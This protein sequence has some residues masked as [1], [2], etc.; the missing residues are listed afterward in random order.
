[1][2]NV[3]N[4]ESLDMHHSHT[5]QET[6]FV[7]KVICTYSKQHFGIPFPPVPQRNVDIISKPLHLETF[8]LEFH[9]SFSCF[10]AGPGLF[11]STEPHGAPRNLALPCAFRA[12]YPMTGRQGAVLTA[13]LSSWLR[14]NSRCAGSC[15][16]Q[17][18]HV[19]LAFGE[20]T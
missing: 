2:R 3:S 18:F 10:S 9:F 6:A 16:E 1:M 12:P 14:G 19:S 17:L 13:F 20:M 5:I 7:C 4:A 11:L 15:L 8:D